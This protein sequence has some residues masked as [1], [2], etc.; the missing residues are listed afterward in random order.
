MKEDQSKPLSEEKRT[1]CENVCPVRPSFRE[2]FR[3]AAEQTELWST[4]ENERDA[5]RELCYVIAEIYVIAQDANIKIGEDVLDGALVRAIYEE[6][7]IEHLRFVR[8]NFLKQACPIRKKRA[9]LRTALYTSVFE[10]EAHYDNVASVA[11]AGG[12]K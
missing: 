9:Y 2:A 3:R 5:M 1:H 8:E 11:T 4:D 7:T 12:K 10:L 6:L